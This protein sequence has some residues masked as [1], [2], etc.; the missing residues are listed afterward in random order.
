M[1][2][3]RRRRRVRLRFSLLALMLATALI[4]IAIWLVYLSGG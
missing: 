1:T 3:G 2:I 4:P